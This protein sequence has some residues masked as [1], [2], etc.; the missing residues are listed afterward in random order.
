MKKKS[1]SQRLFEDPSART[2]VAG[3]LEA[4][5]LPGY[6][7]LG[8]SLRHQ[9]V[10]LLRRIEDLGAAAAKGSTAGIPLL[11]PWANRL[12]STSY[13]AAGREV[14]LDPASP[15]LHLDDHGLPMHG[16]PWALLGWKLTEATQDALVARLDWSTNN[17]LA[18][19]YGQT[20]QADLADGEFRKCM[21]EFPSDWL[22]LNNYGLF[23]LER[24]KPSDAAAV[25][26][27]AI[28]LNAENV[29][30]FVGLGEAN[31]QAGRPREANHW[32][33]IAL[34]LDPNQAVAKQYAR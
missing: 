33:R 5:F 16:V 19:A 8:A 21:Q 12:A 18:I 20:F 9:N 14:N 11:H 3:E 22:T 32:Y 1:E 28:D 23:L 15:L 31:R 26:E 13:R 7:M 29:Q 6:G 4:V 34:Q 25:F 2:I 27:K 10:E 24:G 17:L 30:A